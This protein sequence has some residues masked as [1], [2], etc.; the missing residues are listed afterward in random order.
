MF[1]KRSAYPYIKIKDETETTDKSAIKDFPQIL[2]KIIEVKDYTLDQVWNADESILSWKRMLNRTYV[3]NAQKRDDL[4]ELLDDK[5]LSEEKI[6]DVALETPDSK[7]YNNN[8]AEDPVS[9]AG[10]IK[11]GLELISKLGNHF[12]KHDLYEEQAQKF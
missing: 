3:A 10:L 1:F 6:I 9:N 5:A 12:V 8:D 11:E 2:A 4:D 7:D